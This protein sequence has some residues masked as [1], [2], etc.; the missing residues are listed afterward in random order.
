MRSISQKYGLE[1]L[2]TVLQHVTESLQI[3]TFD[4]NS[5]FLAMLDTCEKDVG[6]ICQGLQEEGL[7]STGERLMA[8]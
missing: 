3:D 1:G 8:F 2:R 6:L 4:R 7:G 5:I